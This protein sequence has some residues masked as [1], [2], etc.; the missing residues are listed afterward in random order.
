MHTA[1]PCQIMG[2][3]MKDRGLVISCTLISVLHSWTR[4]LFDSHSS[5]SCSCSLCLNLHLAMC[6]GLGSRSAFVTFQYISVSR[7]LMAE[8]VWHKSVW[9]PPEDGWMG[10]GLVW[11]CM[12]T[13][14]EFLCWYI[15]VNL[16]PLS[17]G[18]LRSASYW[19]TA[20]SKGR[21]VISLAVEHK[22]HQ[23]TSKPKL[24]FMFI[25]DK[26]IIFD[27]ALIL[28]NFCPQFKLL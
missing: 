22:H 7:A 27:G 5:G 26:Q 15:L 13:C 16:G 28:D 2:M 4:V 18:G 12:K 24:N 19:P 20:V 6:F 8:C 9:H 14:S 25:N 17:H 23:L 1:S 11:T 21:G 3:R 10:E